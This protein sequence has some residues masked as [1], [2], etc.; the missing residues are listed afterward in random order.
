MPLPTAVKTFEIVQTIASVATAVGVGI[1]GWQLRVTKQQ[2]QTQFEDSLV[3]Q[4]RRITANIPLDALLGR[5]LDPDALQA[6]L[7]AFY[8][9]F[10]LSNEQAFLAAANRL[11]ASTWANWREGIEQHF[12]RV[13]FQQ[14]WAALS[15]ALDGSFDDL[16]AGF[17][18]ETAT[19][20]SRREEPDS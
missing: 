3:A 15:P 16:R 12:R 13:A 8:N 11:R 10:D 9:Y 20:P 4:Y 6:S 7:R 14:A 1:A 5:H 18:Q 2:A 19:L 17:P